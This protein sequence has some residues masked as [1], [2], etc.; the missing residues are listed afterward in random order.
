MCAHVHARGV[1][2]EHSQ[3]HRCPHTEAKHLAHVCQILGAGAGSKDSGSACESQGPVLGLMPPLPPWALD[4]HRNLSWS[5]C[6]VSEVVRT[7]RRAR[8]Q[9]HVCHSSCLPCEHSEAPRGFFCDPQL[10]TTRFSLTV[11]D[12]ESPIDMWGWSQGVAGP[13]RTSMPSNPARTEDSFPC[14]FPIF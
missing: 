8:E 2:Y 9:R 14:I 1:R 3:W 7:A 6:P 5:S 12:F 11:S 13:H 4:S 10:R